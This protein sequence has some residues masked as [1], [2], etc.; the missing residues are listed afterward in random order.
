INT[1]DGGFAGILVAAIE[2]DDFTNFL[3][4]IGIGENGAV[5]VWRTDGKLIL[6]QPMEEQYL[7]RDFSELRLFRVPFQEAPSGI[8][9]SDKTV[10]GIERLVAYQ[11]MQGF[12]LAAVTSIPSTA[13]RQVWYSNVKNY[14]IIGLLGF[15]GLAGLSWL[16]Y[17][18]VAR[19]DVARK[20]LEK[21]HDQVTKLNAELEQR[22]L[23]RTSQ[24][25]VANNDL[26]E[27]IIERRKAEEALRE[28]EIFLKETQSIARVG[29][30]KAN[31]DTDFLQWTEGVYRIIEAPLDF[32]A[33]L[34]EG[35]KF[36]LPQYIPIL[37][38]KLQHS[39][40]TGEPFGL[41]C[42][43]AT[44]TGKR[45]WTEV[46]GLAHRIEG[47]T[48]SVV[49]TFQ[50][51]TERKR[52]ENELR[53]S[54]LREQER[55]AELAALFDAAPTPIFIA[56]DPDCFHITGNRA[57]D[58]LLRHPHGAEGLPDCARRRQTPPLPGLQG[59]AGVKR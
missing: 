15:L 30:W 51:I 5:A 25:S 34:A 26:N 52:A 8:F 38:E 53:A 50:D 35:L 43:V 7:D 54:Q 58:N 2:T 18:S 21:A 57:A 22:V 17:K 47:K 44:T 9:F 4:N 32:R 59:R 40:A 24:L 3:R 37:R 14:T 28:S 1:K 41:E 48:S 6:R 20:E 36:C 31:P 12:P 27:E 13:I 46:R 49:G 45:L 33:G 56:H 39:L 10:D 29:G 11:K 55:A 16:V 23:E 19:E 42:E